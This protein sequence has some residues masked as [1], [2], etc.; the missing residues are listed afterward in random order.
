M[1]SQT[2]NGFTIIETI[3]FLG[4]AGA[5]AV[6]VLAGSG[7]AINQQRYRDSVNS[8]KSFIQQQYSEVTNV[9]NAREGSEACAANA[10]VAQP[11]AIVTPQSRGTSDC[12]M[13]GRYVTVDNTGK[14]L[15][16]SNVVGY[17][18]IGAPEAV[19]DIAEVTTNYRLGISTIDQDTAD[20]AWGAVVVKE[21]TSQ[22]MPMSMLIL[23][24]P[25][26]GSIMTY[27]SQAPVANIKSMVAIANSDKPLNLCL[28]TT[29]GAVGGKRMA[30]QIGAFA[31]SQ[32]AI[33]IP[34][35]STGVCD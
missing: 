14:K 15:T 2:N 4:V 24:S 1:G 8:L 35:E 11:P 17:R 31:T 26:S 9:V 19:S 6:G 7:L 33:Q 12:I 16:A 13:L 30:V 10:V 23:R 27:T 32:G 25:L 18:T 34:V 22:A 28:D 21:K 3:L 29:I 5:L 20:V